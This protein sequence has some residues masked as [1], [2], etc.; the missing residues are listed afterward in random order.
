MT[1]EKTCVIMALGS[2]TNCRRNIKD[3]ADCLSQYLSGMVVSSVIQSAAVDN[4]YGVYANMLVAGSTA[5]SY[6]NLRSACKR[7]EQSFGDMPG[8]HATGIV[9]IDID[10]LQH[11]DT[12]HH[13][14][15]WNR[16]YICTLMEEL[17]SKNIKIQDYE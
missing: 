13:L 8:S 6:P 5:L 16:R 14:R 9:N 10:I 7:I 17:K 4:G 11:G 1:E 12:R 2:N 3:A 15:D